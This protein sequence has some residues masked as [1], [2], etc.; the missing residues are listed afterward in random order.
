MASYII[1]GGDNCRSYG[2]KASKQPW[3]YEPQVFK[4]CFFFFSFKVYTCF[5]CLRTLEMCVTQ[6]M[7]T[8]NK[9]N[10]DDKVKHVCHC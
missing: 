9:S 8:L 7:K 3:S 5:A 1:T 2:L 4:R 10:E 6:V